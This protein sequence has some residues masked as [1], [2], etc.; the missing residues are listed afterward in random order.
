M[1]VFLCL[2]DYCNVLVIIFVLFTCYGCSSTTM[3][4]HGCYHQKNFT[5]VSFTYA[6]SSYLQQ[7]Y[8]QLANQLLPC[9][10]QNT[11]QEWTRKPNLF[12]IDKQTFILKLG[13]LLNLGSDL[14]HWKWLYNSIFVSAVPLSFNGIYCPMLQY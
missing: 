5:L 1:Y 3:M 13:K 14:A 7:N 10:Q 6:V 4:C 2:Y 9:I 11:W 12:L 8:C